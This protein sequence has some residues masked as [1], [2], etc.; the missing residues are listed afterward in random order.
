M[1][2]EPMARDTAQTRTLKRALAIAGSVE[3]L[4]EALECGA[5]ELGL[6]LGGDKSTPTDVY[7]RALD[8]VS[9]GPRSLPRGK[10]EG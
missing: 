9:G 5:A 3:H 8:I 2:K 4:A 1:G 7:L 10:H 6:W